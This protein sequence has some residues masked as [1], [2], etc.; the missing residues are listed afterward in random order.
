MERA[1]L[2]RKE[3]IYGARGGTEL[4][5]AREKLWEETKWNL[6]IIFIYIYMYVCIKKVKSSVF[7]GSAHCQRPV[8][9]SIIQSM[10]ALK[11]Q[12]FSKNLRDV[13]SGV[14]LETI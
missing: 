6:C 12:E 14:V 1:V 8:M 4:V 13:V 11:D 7:R 10:F 5:G 9:I 2:L 3:R